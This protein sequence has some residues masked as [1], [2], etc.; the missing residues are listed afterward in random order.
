MI[1][2]SQCEQCV[3]T[4]TETVAGGMGRVTI[5]LAHETTCPN[6]SEANHAA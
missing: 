3:P 1:R 6:H 4:L 5:E 2:P